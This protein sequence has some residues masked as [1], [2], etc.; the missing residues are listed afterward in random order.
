M[1]YPPGWSAEQ[2]PTVLLRIPSPLVYIYLA[3]EV[4]A[5]D[6][7]SLRVRRVQAYVHAEFCVLK[8]L[9]FLKA[10]QYGIDHRTTADWRTKK[11]IH[12]GVFNTPPCIS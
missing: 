3:G 12:G 2:E 9:L 11:P 10:K 1:T 8:V 7:T 6:P 5:E 4:Q